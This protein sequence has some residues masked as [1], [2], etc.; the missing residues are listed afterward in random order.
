MYDG[1]RFP[2][3]QLHASLERDQPPTWYETEQIGY[4]SGT[5]WGMLG[6]FSGLGTSHNLAIGKE[7]P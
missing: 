7:L 6:I 5:W 4:E 2:G 1:V 3:Q